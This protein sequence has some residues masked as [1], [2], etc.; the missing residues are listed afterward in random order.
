MAEHIEHKYS[1]HEYACLLE[2]C[3]IYV[4]VRGIGDQPSPLYL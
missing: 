1:F 3:Y 2:V 4:N